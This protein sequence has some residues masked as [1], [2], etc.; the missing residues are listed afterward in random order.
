MVYDVISKYS[1][2]EQKECKTRHELEIGK[3]ILIWL[4]E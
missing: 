2:L 1:K 4:Y 3:E